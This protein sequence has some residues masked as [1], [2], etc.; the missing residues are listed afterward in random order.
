MDFSRKIII[1]YS[2]VANYQNSPG[3][4]D[5]YRNATLIKIRASTV[6]I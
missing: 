3:R 6:T 1:K 5:N 2:K 4:I